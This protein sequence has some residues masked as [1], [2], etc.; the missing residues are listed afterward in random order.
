[1]RQVSK[2]EFIKII[3]EGGNPERVIEIDTTDDYPILHAWMEHHGDSEHLDIVEMDFELYPDKYI[4][5]AFNVPG[6]NA[7]GMYYQDIPEMIPEED[8]VVDFAN[9]GE[10]FIITEDILLSELL[11][12][13]DPE[14]KIMV[15]ITG[16]LKEE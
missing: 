15:Y 12:Q 9:Y 10:V 8:I 2:Y 5:D 13:L 6:R 14:D 4:S 3:N 16:E 11:N 7:G 1:M